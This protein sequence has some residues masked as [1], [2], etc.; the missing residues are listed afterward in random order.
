MLQCSH[1]LLQVDPVSLYDLSVTV[2]GTHL[3]DRE[4]GPSSTSTAGFLTQLWAHVQLSMLRGQPWAVCL[5]G[6]CTS[7]GNIWPSMF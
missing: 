4:I 7:F 5:L 3:A 1:R 6:V 2:S